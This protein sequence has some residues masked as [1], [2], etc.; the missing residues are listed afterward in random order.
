MELTETQE[1]IASAIRI[2][3]GDE[4]F[5][6]IADIADYTGLAKKTVHNNIHEVMEKRGALGSRKVGQ[7]NVYYQKQSRFDD[8][9]DDDTESIIRLFSNSE[10]EYA[11]VRRAPETSDFDYFV[12]WYDWE[13]KELNG[14]HPTNE[15]VGRV[16]GAYAEEPVSIRIQK[17]PD[18]EE[19]TGT[20][21]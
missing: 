15:Q 18:L 14:Y 10:A 11:E 12:R 19:E 17:L 6:T 1:Q 20:S 7:A 5:C 8:I 3:C 13:G 4:P 2:L 9:G 21:E 16:V